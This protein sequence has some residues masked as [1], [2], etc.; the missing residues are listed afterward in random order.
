[1]TTAIQPHQAA[2]H[3]LKLRRS[4]HDLIAFSQYTMPGY[5]APPH[6]VRLADRL[7]AID[8]GELKRLIVTMPPRHGKSTEVS[9]LFPCW[10][11]GRHPEAQIVQAGYAESIALV[12]SRAARTVFNDRAMARVFP[13]V[14]ERTGPKTERQA[15]Q[16]WETTRGGKYYAVGVGGGLTGRGFS[17]IIIDDPTKDAEEANSA[18]VRQ[19][20]WDW[21][22][23][24]VRTR[25][26]PDAAMIVVSTRWHVDDL[27]GRLLKAAAAGGEQWEILHLPALDEDGKALWPERYDEDALQSILATLGTRAFTSLYQ[28]DPVVAAGNIIKREWIQ[29]YD[30]KP[31]VDRLVHSWDTAFKKNQANDPSAGLVW[32]TTSNRI[33]LLDVVNERMEFPELK[34][35][36]QAMWERDGARAVL[37]EDAASGQSLIQELRRETRMPILPVKAVGDKESRVHAIAPLFEAGRVFV[38]RSAPWLYDY[39]EQLCGFPTAPHDDM[40]D[41]TTQALRYLTVAEE[42][43]VVYEYD[44][45]AALGMDIDL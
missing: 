27:V 13:S 45:M 20:N 37:V 3:L 7:E 22:T 41:A 14:K 21:Y 38:P 36:C 1:V 4:R 8:R 15:A 44:T 10:H 39:L 28:G 12:H 40:V 11:L 2:D 32:G 25:A 19:A 33:Y 29:Y 35:T 6:L 34:R 18:R 24:V 30:V 16:E 5:M 31:A 43:D 42:Q 9:V 23:Q 26:E 17:L